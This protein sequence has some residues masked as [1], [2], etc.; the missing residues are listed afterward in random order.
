ML[1]QYH[2]C[3][4]FIATGRQYITETRW[5]GWRKT[6]TKPKSV[7]ALDKVIYTLIDKIVVFGN[8]IT[9]QGKYRVQ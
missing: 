6:G 1:V 9:S 5:Q 2:L 7:V 4:F 8:M 3:N